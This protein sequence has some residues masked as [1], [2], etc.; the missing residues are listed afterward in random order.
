MLQYLHGSQDLEL[1]LEAKNLS[2]IE[3]WADASFAVHKDMKSHTGGIMKMGNGA[4]QTI[5]QKQKL[6]T[7]SSTE[8]EL[9]GAD[10]VISHLI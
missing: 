6:N 4:I 3:W 2:V 9:I 5:S 8:A 1:T 10:D 7:K